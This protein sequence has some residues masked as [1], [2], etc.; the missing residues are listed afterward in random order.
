MRGSGRAVPADALCAAVRVHADRVHDF[1]RRQGCGPMSSPGV[2]EASALDLVHSADRDPAPVSV[3]VGRWF[4]IA[5]RLARHAGPDLG[6]DEAGLR[7]GRGLL[8]EDPEQAQLR[9]GLDRREER[10]RS[11]LLLSDAY[12]LPPD[13][14]A[15]A[16]G[17]DRGAAMRLVGQARLE[18]L[19]DV[20]DSGAPDD[21]RRLLTGLSVLA[22]PD[23]CRDPL[24][25]RV[26]GRALAVLP[27]QPSVDQEAFDEGHE[28]GRLL[29][30]GPVLLALLLA[31]AAGVGLGVLLHRPE[32]V[33]AVEIGPLPPV[34]A[35]PPP[36]PL[37]GEP[38]TTLT[39]PPLPTTTVFTYAPTP[40][41]T[42]P[43]PPMTAPP[44]TTAAPPTA[45][46]TTAPTSAS[47]APA[48]T[49]AVA[50]GSG[51][52]GTA[53]VVTGTGW[54]PGSTVAVVLLD[55]RARPTD[56]FTTAVGPAGRWRGTLDVPKDAPPGDYRIQA[57]DG[58][59][60]ARTAYTVV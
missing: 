43:P 11:A 39:N 24:L 56:T 19:P 18:L 46:P 1:V 29:A 30:P 51:P 5:G 6:R 13:A 52:P 38:P 53:L 59:R 20:L 42:A 60:T 48:P 25:E 32:P 31:V 35:A 41:P 21:V 45:A 55:L 37:P 16:L 57:G 9:E 28:P 50:P 17:L 26:A 49:V 47:P 36:T 2:V 44:P 10:S 58:S 12:D 8:A 40:A 54:T 14:V 33:R 27:A 22:L 23:E 7:A 4:A 34:T 3:L 15:A